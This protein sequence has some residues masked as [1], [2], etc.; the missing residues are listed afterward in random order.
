VDLDGRRVRIKAEDFFAR[1]LQHEIDHL[2]GILFV[3]RMAKDA[4]LMPD[5]DEEED[6][7]GAATA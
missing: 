3:D 1:V 5:R 2:D 6:V 7:I 4:K